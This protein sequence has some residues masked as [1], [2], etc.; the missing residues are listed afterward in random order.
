MSPW[1]A[2][3]LARRGVATPEDAARFLAPDL[4]QLHD[5]CALAGLEAAVARLLRARDDGETVAI[6]GDYDVDGVS[7]TALLVAVLGACG[8]EV[9]PIIPHRMRDGYGFQPC[10]AERAADLGCAVVVTVDC[11]TTAIAAAEAAS[12]RGL[13]VVITDH[14]LPGPALPDGVIQINPRQ[15]DCS[16][17]FEDLSGAGIALKLAQGVAAASGRAINLRQLLRVA[18]LGTIADL[19]PLR[20]E[21]RVIAALGLSALEHTRSPG[22]QALIETAGLERPFSTADIGYRIGPRLN[23]PGRLDSAEKALE[24]LLSRDAGRARDL[25]LEVDGWNRDRRAAEQRVVEEAREMLTARDELPPILVAWHEGWHRGVVGIAA[26]RLAREL[27]RP[28]L[29]LA[30][31]GDGE[32][33]GEGTD[34]DRAG[35]AT[36]SGRSI[37]GIHL[38]D[39]L[40]RWRERMPRFGGHA[41]AIGLTVPRAALEPLRREWEAAAAADR[42]WCDRVASRRLEYELALDAA[43]V[44][45]Q[46]LAALSRLEPHGQGNPQPLIRVKGPLRLLGPPRRFG[47]GHLSARSRGAGGGMLRLLGWG[48]AVREDE[49]EGDFE[50]LGYLETDRYS[51]GVTLRL[52]DVRAASGSPDAA[53]APRNRP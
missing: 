10:H 29:L 44:D 27:N 24:L 42:A 7:G 14:H 9:E 19:V 11:G 25:A 47:N 33:D 38:Y 34:G 20:G 51:G 16:Y 21:N 32:S 52:V 39:F 23:A 41:Q 36:G 35:A 1:L 15:H 22:L 8:I 43:Q 13:D 45:R 4:D 28:T 6:V 50:A 53:E 5:P 49:L 2:P 37:P 3:L 31:H 48:W 18:C 30:L 17:P 46:L 12:A 40:N 26:G